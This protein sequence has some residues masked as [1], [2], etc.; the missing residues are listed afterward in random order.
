MEYAIEAWSVTKT[1][2]KKRQSDVVALDSVSIGVPFGAIHGLVGLNGAGKTTL[3]KI[4][5]GIL[6]PDAGDTFLNGYHVRNERR[7]AIQAVGAVLEG[8]RNVYWRMSPMENLFYF[9]RIRGHD[10]GE[11]YKRAE[12]LISFFDL[13]AKRNSEVSELSRGMQQKVAIAAALITNPP[14]LVLDEPTIALDVEMSLKVRRYLR[15]L[16]E[17]EGKAI[18]LTTHQMNV[19]EEV[20]DYIHIIKTGR[21]VYGGTPADLRHQIG[22]DGSFEGVIAE[23]LRREAS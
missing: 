5:L 8:A 13:T 22:K 11:I 2:K 19:A 10:G 21:Y 23:L 18:L 3:I 12:K 16:V 15:V 9:A 4:V 14:I 20:C 7:D 1:Y 17:Q 6:I